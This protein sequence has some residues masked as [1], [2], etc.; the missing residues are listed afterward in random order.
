[1]A[2]DGVKSLPEGEKKRKYLDISGYVQTSDSQELVYTTSEFPLISSSL[3]WVKEEL[4]LSA[5]GISSPILPIHEF[6]NLSRLS[7]LKMNFNDNLNSSI[8]TEIINLTALSVLE[9]AGC[10]NLQGSI[11]T[12]PQIKRLDVRGNTY[13]QVNLSV[14]FERQFPRLQALWISSVSV[15]GSIPSSISNAPELLSLVASDCYLKRSLPT[16]ISALSKLEYLDLSENHITGYVPSFGSNTKNLQY[17]TFFQNKFQGPVP[18]SIC[19]ITSLQKLDFSSNELSN[20]LPSCITKLHNLN[21]LDVSSNSFEGIFSLDSLINELS[22]TESNLNSNNITIEIDE[23]ELPS[24]FQLESLQL[25]SCNMEGH[26]PAFFCKF[27]NLST[28]DLSN[29]N[30]MGSIPSC[31]FKHQNLQYLDLSQNNIQGTMPRAF[32]FDPSA[33][34]YLNLADN[35]LQGSLPLPSPR[36]IFFDLSN[37]QFSGG[38][39]FEVGKRL[40]T[41]RYASLSSNQLSGT[42]PLSFCL[43]GGLKIPFSIG[44]LNL[45]NNTLTGKIPSSMG[46]CS[47][48]V[49][50]HLGMN[51]LT[52]H[53]PNEIQQIPIAYLLLNDNFLEGIFPKFI[54]QFQKLEVLSLGNNRFDGRIPTFIG[55]FEEIKILSLRSNSFNGSMPKEISHLGQLQVLDLSMNNLSGSIPSKLGNLT[56]LTSRPNYSTA[57]WGGGWIISDIQLSIRIDGVLQ[58]LKRLH[59]YTSGIDLSSNIL[60]G[61]IPE[62][63]GLLQGLSM[64]NLSNNHLDGK[65][66]RSVGN[67]TGLDSLDVSFNELSGEIPMEFTSLDSFGY[68]NLSYNNLSGR[69]PDDAHFQSPGVDGLAFLGNEFLCGIPTKKHCEGDPVGPTS[70]KPDDNTNVNVEEEENGFWGPFLVLICKKEKWWFRYWRAVDTAASRLTGCISKNQ[71]EKIRAFGTKGYANISLIK[72]TRDIQ[73]EIPWCML[74]ENGIA[75]IGESK[76]EVDEKLELW[77]HTLESKGF[78]LSSTKTEYLRCDSSD[79]GTDAGDILKYGKLVPRTN[80]F[81]YLGSIIQKDGGIE[82]DIRQQTQSGWEKWRLASGVLCDGKVPLKLIGKFYKTA[83]SPAMLYGAE[84]WAMNNRDTLKLNS[85]EMRMLGWICN[86]MRYD[87]IRNEYVRKKLMVAPIEAML[88]QHRMRWFGHLR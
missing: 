58:Y 87:R 8:P 7:T 11:P 27:T 81:R 5:S 31:L 84:C 83:T 78:K 30:L 57:D 52:G 66:P 40:S 39:S 18:E 2:Y 6:L 86:H 13:L 48:L 70:N 60:E 20:M 56:M 28:L 64:L 45:S 69:I 33:F 51:N 76:E 35:K 37:N 32:H 50:L 42:I 79:S 63:I 61:N 47:S 67:M 26:I 34:M 25:Q 1:M 10:Y 36:N 17:L 38:I 4:H 72:D 22:L 24:K 77:R 44:S 65:I 55:S 16:T 59:N 54:R 82:E 73:G 9:L 62:E 15:N 14:M 23:N 49:F 21:Y 41:S 46:N 12:L 43:N 53:I 3:N 19:D 75:L 71:K 85:S 88:S 74:F 68:I 80:S 29:N